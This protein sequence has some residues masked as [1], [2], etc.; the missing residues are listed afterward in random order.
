VGDILVYSRDEKRARPIHPFDASGEARPNALIPYVRSR[1]L[2]IRKTKFN[3]STSE[4]I[5]P[6]FPTWGSAEKTARLA[7]LY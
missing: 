3:P 1:A 6:P 5:R 2:C 4:E 7:E